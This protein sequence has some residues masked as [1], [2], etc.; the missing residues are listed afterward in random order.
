MSNIPFVLSKRKDSTFYYVRFKI[1]SGKY[2]TAI[3]TKQTDKKQAEKTAWEWYR[4]GQIERPRKSPGKIQKKIKSIDELLLQESIKNADNELLE[5]AIS[6]AKKRGIIKAVIYAGSKSDI[7]AGQFLLDFWDWDKSKYIAEKLRKNHSIGKRHCSKQTSNIKN[8]WLP[9]LQDKT[10]GE[11]TRQDI[12]SFIDLIAD[13]ERCFGAKNDIVRA[14]TTAFKWA[15][16]KGIIDDDLYSN[17]IFFSGKYNER[18]ILTP[19][20]AYSIFSAA[21]HDERAKLANMLAMCTGLRAGEIQGLR[22]Q[23]LGQDKLYINHSWNLQD[24]LKCTKNGESRIVY[25]PFKQLIQA[26]KELAESN[27]HNQGLDG[28]VFWSTIPDKPMES[29]TWLF[30]LRQMLKAFGVA[31]VNKYTFH[32]WRHYFTSY[33]ADYVNPKILQRQTGHKTMEMLEHYAQHEIDGDIKRLENAQLEIFGGIVNQSQSFNF[34]QKK[35]LD[36][37]RNKETNIQN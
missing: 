36:Y 3:S 10:L 8:Y 14:G 37:V 28:F 4:Q 11:L 18:A 9:F 23:D 13:T 12:D 2:S 22:L 32:A 29:K 24:G 31:D 21:W 5:I 33:M 20:I 30:E 27:P 16:S 26:L 17:I 34:N 7:P 35:M 25:L 6:T 19:E 15:K 1:E